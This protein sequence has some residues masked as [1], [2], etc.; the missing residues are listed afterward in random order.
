MRANGSAGNVGYVPSSVFTRSSYRTKQYPTL[1]SGHATSPPAYLV[2]DV[3][4]TSASSHNRVP[5][6]AL[7]PPLI[8]VDSTAGGGLYNIARQRASHDFPAHSSMDDLEVIGLRR[9]T[10]AT[11]VEPQSVAPDQNTPN[12]SADFEWDFGDENAPLR[13][14]EH[15]VV[16]GSHPHHHQQQQQQHQHQ[17]QHH[18]HQHH[19]FGSLDRRRRLMS[20]SASKMALGSKSMDEL[21][22]SS[23]TPVVDVIDGS[24]IGPR[25]GGRGLRPK[26]S[27]SSLGSN[28]YN[29]ADLTLLPNQTYP[30]YP[31]FGASY[32]S[33][34]QQQ[35]CSSGRMETTFDSDVYTS[36]T[37][38]NMSTSSILSVSKKK[39]K[40]WY[41]TSLDSPV[42]SRK[43]TKMTP[44]VPSGAPSLTVVPNVVPTSVAAVPPQPQTSGTSTVRAQ[45][46]RVAEVTS[47]N[48]DGDCDYGSDDFGTDSPAMVVP[49]E[50]PK[51]MEIISPGKWEPYRE[52][53]KPFETSDIYKY[54]A[55]YRQQQQQQQQ[56]HH[57][58][59]AG[60]VKGMYQPLMPMSCQPLNS[61]RHVDAETVANGGGTLKTLQRPLTT[62]APSEFRSKPATLV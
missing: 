19:R 37:V 6:A 30:D 36:R 56:Q 13:R 1:S 53:S 28:G 15:L 29:E 20:E 38:H 43:N 44:P 26:L 48:G 10:G 7:C 60:Q 16:S 14:L 45:P 47:E 11:E 22:S 3:W 12:T 32:T 18:Q 8:G 4:D 34:D 23:P 42:P 27:H 5:S 61:A 40:D 41:E 50:S 21:D 58:L 59:S 54:S 2:K 9:L 55:K 24:S 39:E 49:Y 57:S 62:P 51:N 33:S 46:V 31:D 52:I 35:H 25:F 17:Q